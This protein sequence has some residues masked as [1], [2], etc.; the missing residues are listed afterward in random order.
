MLEVA[1]WLSWKD[2]W[3]AEKNAEIRANYYNL[4]QE[5]LKQEELNILKFQAFEA[6]RPRTTNCYKDLFGG[7]SCTQF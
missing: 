7:F 1:K 6:S 2:G 5:T 4:Q 3:L